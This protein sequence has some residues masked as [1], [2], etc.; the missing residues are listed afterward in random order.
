[1]SDPEQSVFDRLAAFYA[2]G[3]VPWDDKDPPPEVMSYLATVP[4]GM[5][6]DLGCG[7]GRAAIYMARQGWEVD[8]V[9]FIPDAVTEGAKR[10]AIARLDVRFHLSKVTE[11]DFLTGIYDFALDVGCSH[12]LNY[13]ELEVYRGQLERLIRSGGLYMLFARLHDDSGEQYRDDQ[14]G[15]PGMDLHDVQALYSEGFELEWMEQG[16][17]QVGED[18]SWLSAWFQF[19][20]T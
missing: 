1:M 6:L 7:Y 14:D 2:S 17:T 4:P 16:R 11:L 13:D 9:D 5:A 19:R 3:D 8:A 15:P 20:R 12:S 18:A 10:A